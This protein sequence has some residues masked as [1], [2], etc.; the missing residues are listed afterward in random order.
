[1]KKT[2]SVLCFLFFLGLLIL[3]QFKTV[4]RQNDYPHGDIQFDCIECHSSESW[5]FKENGSSF[6]HGK[7]G[8]PLVGGHNNTDC[9][10]C[11]EN[12]VFSNMIS[13]EYIN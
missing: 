11:H 5:Q 4:A 13:L 6:D 12:L 3:V 7:T 9:R 10:S 8:F 2:Y 1:M